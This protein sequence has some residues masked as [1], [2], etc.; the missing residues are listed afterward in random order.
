MA[1]EMPRARLTGSSVQILFDT[2]DT[3]LDGSISPEELIVLIVVSGING[4]GSFSADEK[5][6][7]HIMRKF[8]IT[9]SS[10]VSLMH[11]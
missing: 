1:A 2:L 10:E 7:R 6:S 11:I 4:S 5:A 9:P 8:E 3:D